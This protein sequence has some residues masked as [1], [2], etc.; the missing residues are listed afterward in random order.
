[1]ISEANTYQCNNVIE[2]VCAHFEINISDLKSI[3]RNAPLPDLRCIILHIIEEM[4]G[5]E[6]DKSTLHELAHF[7]G[8]NDHSNI[9]ASR[10]KFNELYEFNYSFRCKYD[11]AKELIDNSD[12]T[13]DSK[14][15]MELANMPQL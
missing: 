4:L 14:Y 3:K 6:L 8:K 11:V 7:V 15:I 9:L 2:L 1:M 13:M 5:D 12:L 10:K